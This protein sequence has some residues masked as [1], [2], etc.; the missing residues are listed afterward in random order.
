MNRRHLLLGAALLVCV[1][2]TAW[3]LLADGDTGVVLARAPSPRPAPSSGTPHAAA[4]APRETPAVAVLELPQRPAARGSARNAFGAYSYLPPP[5]R[6]AIT[7]APAP[8][9]PP[10]PFIFTGSLVIEGQP[11][12]LLLQGDAPI[13]V[14]PGAQVGD[15]T[16]VEAAPERLVFRHGPTGDLVPLTI[17]SARSN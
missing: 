9:A 15:F 2:W 4:A 14:S 5:P 13:R 12:Y 3:S 10:L 6:A 7:A 11:S 8:R 17:V 16:L 1:A